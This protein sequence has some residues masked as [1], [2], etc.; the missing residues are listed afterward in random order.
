VILK[1][2]GGIGK[3]LPQD[4]DQLRRCDVH[5]LPCMMNH[6]AFSGDPG[7]DDPVAFSDPSISC[8][9]T[10]IPGRTVN[11]RE[12]DRQHQPGFRPSNPGVTLE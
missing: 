5:G 1:L 12:S 11:S 2:S 8:R 6:D 10:A 4:F 7:R 9:L 3:L